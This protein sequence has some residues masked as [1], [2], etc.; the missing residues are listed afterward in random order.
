MTIYNKIIPGCIII[1]SLKTYHRAI[2]IKT[3]WYTYGNEQVGQWNQI[4]D[5]EISHTPTNT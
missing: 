4:E 1:P 3:A 5:P 2:R